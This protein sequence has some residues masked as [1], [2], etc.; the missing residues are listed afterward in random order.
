MLLEVYAPWCGHCQGFEGHYA[1][2]GADLLRR[3]GGEIVRVG[4]MDGTANVGRHDT[5]AIWVAFFSSRW[6]RY[7][8]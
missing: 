5:A 8:C 4:K 7:R 1:A 3:Y 2:V 6:Q